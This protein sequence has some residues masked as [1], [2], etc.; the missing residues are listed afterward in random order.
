[1]PQLIENAEIV[2]HQQ[3]IDDLIGIA[4]NWLLRSGI[5]SIALVFISILT[6]CA[7]IK[8]PDKITSFGVMTSDNPPISHVT[9]TSGI[10]DSL[11]VEE[12]A[13][14]EPNTLIAYIENTMNRNHLLQ[15]K[16]FM[17]EYDQI[18][19]LPDYLNLSFP[20]GLE[21]GMISNNYAQLELL[22]SEFILTLRKAGVFQQIRT[23]HSEIKRTQE[24]RAIQQKEKQI[25]SNEM[26]LLEK[27]LDR[28]KQLYE[29]GTVSEQKYENQEVEWL[30]FQ[31]QYNNLDNGIVQNRIREER[32]RLEI[33][34]LKEQRAS[35]VQSHR[36][37]IQ[38]S[39]NT[40]QQQ[41]QR[42][43]EQYLIKATI[44]GQVTWKPDI[45]QH[46][47]VAGNTS[48]ASVIP[49]QGSNKK[50]VKA[51]TSSQGLGKLETGTKAIIKVDGY[52]YKEYGV[53]T[54]EILDIST[55][56]IPRD[57]E[58]DGLP[59]YELKVDLPD[60]LETNYRKRIKYKPESSVT[61]E[62]I[63]KD[64]SI[65]ERLFEQ[66]LTLLKNE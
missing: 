33:Q 44:H 26:K 12:G 50:Y 56:P 32:L 11:F 57:N 64:K 18:E 8:Y 5:M 16:K 43:E 6:M 39:I 23:L 65:L 9:L 15:L 3:N 21:L 49:L 36:Y 29:S 30:R 25:A 28:I 63:T 20:Q 48:I 34:Q 52:P 45:K 53:I 13:F 27:D 60:S 58:N 24:L 35:T 61:V 47:F 38:E 42:W 2:E 62:L 55:I 54:S 51:Y 37:S 4:P 41:I 10:I 40:I 17:N 22:Y 1:M 46:S 7:F 66:L 31:K 14:V 59:L 19:Y